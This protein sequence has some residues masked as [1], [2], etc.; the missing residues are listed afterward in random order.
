MNKK[1]H[2]DTL[3]RKLYKE[4]EKEVIP[5][6]KKCPEEDLFEKYVHEELSDEEVELFETHMLSCSECL[7]TLEVIRTVEQAKDSLLD[8]PAKLYEKAGKTLQKELKR[9]SLHPKRLNKRMIT[10][11]WDQIKDKIVQLTPD[12]EG[13]IPSKGPEFQVVRKLSHLG[14]K[15]SSFPYQTTIDVDEGK[16]SFEIYRSG[17]EKFLALKITFHFVSPKIPVHV[18]ATLY[19]TEKIYSSVFLDERGEAFFHQIKEG[20]YHLDFIEGEK[21]LESIEFSILLL[22]ND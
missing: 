4:V 22:K 21:T 8:V 3:F 12:L 19:K 2:L 1:D 5:P 7:E 14:K 15:F 18:R 9:V 6:K 20:E 13:M 16:I 11:L 17:K 10:L